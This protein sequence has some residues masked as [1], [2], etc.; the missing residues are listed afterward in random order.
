M[1]ESCESGCLQQNGKGP[2]AENA[3]KLAEKLKMAHRLN[4]GKKWPEKDQKMET[5]PKFQFLG[6]L[7]P[8]VPISGRGPFPPRFSWTSNPFRSILRHVQ[9]VSVSFNQLQPTLVSVNQCDNRKVGKTT[10]NVMAIAGKPVWAW[11]L[12]IGADFWEGAATRH[13]SVGRKGFF[14][15]KGGGNSVNEGFG[16]D[17]YRKGNSMKRSGLFSEPPD[18]DNWKVVLLVPFPKISS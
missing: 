16:K 17:F 13:F 11:L 8:F 7:R 9:S 15:E 1:W 14:S 12:R 5:W 10:R 18:S 6:N 3:K 4:R 2:K